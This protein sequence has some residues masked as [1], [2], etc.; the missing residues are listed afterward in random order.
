MQH[1]GK[2]KDEVDEKRRRDNNT[3][4]SE[5]LRDKQV[6]IVVGASGAIRSLRER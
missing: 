2:Y 1:K 3:M 5:K 6:I 4:S